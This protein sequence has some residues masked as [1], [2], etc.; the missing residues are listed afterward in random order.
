MCFYAIERFSC[1]H[2]DKD[3]IPCESFFVNGICSTPQEDNIQ[4][5]DEPRCAKCKEA[6]AEEEEIQNE[7]QKFSIKESL[8]PSAAPR[9]PNSN[10]P[11]IYFKWCIEW[12]RCKH[13]SHS[14]PSDLERSEADPEYLIVSGQGECFD[15]SKAP[16][17]QIEKMK[18]N[19]D[20]KKEDPWDALSRT[21]VA[22]GS[23]SDSGVVPLEEIAGVY[24][25][26]ANSQ[27]QTQ[28]ELPDAPSP[29]SDRSR[30]RAMSEH[31][32]DDTGA[33]KGKGRIGESLA[34]RPVEATAESDGFDDSD[35]DDSDDQAD[36]AAK[37]ATKEQAANMATKDDGDEDGD[38]DDE[39]SEEE[40]EEE[41]KEGQGEESDEEEEKPATVPNWSAESRD[42]IAN[43]DNDHDEEGQMVVGEK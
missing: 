4:A 13:R 36:P 43:G 1:G 26:H 20:Y 7:L 34:Q 19:G 22:E 14:R 12:Q 8:T 35:E 3:L 40:E 38:E 32:D 41:S 37:Q 21:G 23:S 42:R 15:C 29:S 17:W 27:Q 18:Q 10:A 31:S 33:A 25:S 11:K 2:E 24:H 30:R 9:V 39:G 16:A 6:A 5:S 28:D